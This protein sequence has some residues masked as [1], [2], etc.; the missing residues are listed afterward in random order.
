MKAPNTFDLKAY[1][2]GWYSWGRISDCFWPGAGKRSAD[3]DPVLAK[4]AKLRGIYCIGWKAV[5]KP[6]PCNPGVQYIGQTGSF[7]TRMAQFGW[8]AGFWGGREPGHSAGW[9]WA[10][11][12][13]DQLVVSFYPIATSKIPKHM[14][15]GFLHWY[16][17]LALDAYYKACGSLPFVN[18]PKNGVL[19]LD[20]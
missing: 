14:L 9:R 4:L 3:V 1:G 16:E 12:K 5:G 6:S 8:S 19:V 17:A 10:E 18:N 11:N 7:K 2:E 13:N 20:D 15:A